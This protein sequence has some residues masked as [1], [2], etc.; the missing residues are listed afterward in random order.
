MSAVEWED[1]RTRL[2][3]DEAC[4]LGATTGR[5]PDEPTFAAD[6]AA[7]LDFW[8][9]LPMHFFT[10]HISEDGTEYCNC[11]VDAD[12][13]VRLPFGRP[14][15]ESITHWAELPALPGAKERQVLGGGV[16]A[17]LSKA[18]GASSPHEPPASGANAL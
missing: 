3:Q 2:P 11:F 15:T 1:A 14:C 6:S 10:H 18:M 9:V 12:R 4:V 5:Y 13:V 17:A 8:L 16:R 7:A